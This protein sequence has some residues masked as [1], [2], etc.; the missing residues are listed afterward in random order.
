VTYHIRPKPYVP[1]KVKRAFRPRNET[2]S[3]LWLGRHDYRS[4]QITPSICCPTIPCIW[5][6]SPLPPPCHHVSRVVCNWRNG[7]QYQM[8]T[9]TTQP[10][11]RY[12]LVVSTLRLM[13]P[14][15]GALWPPQ[16]NLCDLLS[17]TTEFTNCRPPKPK[18]HQMWYDCFQPKPNDY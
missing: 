15:S 2:E 9:Q 11:P 17:T 7:M 6:L 13:P 12:T 1:P 4:Q 16:L 5:C 18:V 3:E 10:L 14:A 8:Q